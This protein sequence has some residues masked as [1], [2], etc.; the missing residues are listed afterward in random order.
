MPWPSATPK[1]NDP[2]VKSP[3]TRSSNWPRSPQALKPVVTT[4]PPS[5]VGAELKRR[6]QA[7]DEPVYQQL[8]PLAPL[9]TIS[10]LP[11]VE[12]LEGF[13]SSSSLASGPPVQQTEGSHQK[14]PT[15]AAKRSKSRPMDAEAAKK[16]DDQGTSSPSGTL[17]L[18]SPAEAASMPLPQSPISDDKTEPVDDRRS[19]DPERGP[20][21]FHTKLDSRSEES[22]AG[23]TD[24][25][26]GPN[27]EEKDTAISRLN[28]FLPQWMADKLPREEAGVADARA[29]RSPSVAPGGYPG[30]DSTE[31]T[32]IPTPGQASEDPQAEAA[33]LD[34]L[35]PRSTDQSIRPRKSV[36]IAVPNPDKKQGNSERA[37]TTAKDETRTN[38]AASD[39]EEDA[40]Q[41]PEGKHRGE[42]DA[43]V[44]DR[45]L[46]RAEHD[47]ESNE[48]AAAE[49]IRPQDPLQDPENS[50]LQEDRKSFLKPSRI[51][52]HRDDS[53]ISRKSSIAASQ[54]NGDK[55]DTSTL[56]ERESLAPSDADNSSLLPLLSSSPGDARSSRFSESMDDYDRATAG[57][58]AGKQAEVRHETGS[59]SPPV[60]DDL[61]SPSTISSLDV[62]QVE[63]MGRETA[64]EHTAPLIG[65]GEGRSRAGTSLP[66]PKIVVKEASEAED[67]LQSPPLRAPTTTPVQDGSFPRR[68][69]T[70]AALG[71]LSDHQGHVKLPMKRRKL[72]VR[73]ARY[74]VLRQPIL[75]AALGRQVG[76]Q[77]KIAL[78]KLANG[79]LIVIEP[80][81][82]L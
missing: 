60:V 28:S 76:A 9:S 69:T 5:F 7:A 32:S 54:T 81:T 25:S 27:N 35:P 71:E 36:S 70:F 30:S 34:P 26:S 4:C 58:K 10:E 67:S 78:K 40:D 14:E 51:Y 57:T 33:P 41:K 50:A 24:R 53:P 61:S 13:S 79:E 16:N 44:E 12:L 11:K 38:K 68:Q 74:A 65:N 3:R 17:P 48:P 46:R 2:L 21:M 77:T 42:H 43:G 22:K 59:D 15:K 47:E 62:S 29:T 66:A 49:S 37:N 56:H 31:D 52:T 75:K 6:L 23:A 72:Y 73:K 19:P 82:S 63:G 80:P 20:E 45:N 64:S 39:P 1:L 18:A 8:L 55:A